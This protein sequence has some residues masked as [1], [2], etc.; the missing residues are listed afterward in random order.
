MEMMKPKR[1]NRWLFKR[2]I[3]NT[4]L[5]SIDL[6][7]KNSNGD[8]LLNFRGNHPAYHKWFF[9]GGS[10][11]KPEKPRDAFLSIIKR[12]FFSVLKLDFNDAKFTKLAVHQYKEDLTG[13]VKTNEEGIQYYVLCYEFTKDISDSELQNILVLYEENAKR[14]TLIN[15]I[16]TLI[17]FKVEPDVIGIK[18]FSEEQLMKD[19]DVHDNVKLYFKNDPD[20]IIGTGF[21]PPSKI[22]QSSSNS[23]PYRLQSLL[24]LYQTQSKSI[25]SYTT[26]I[27]AFPIVF[28]VALGNIYRYFHQSE[29][30]MILSIWFSVVMHQAFRKHTY[31][32][33]VLKNSLDAIERSI[34]EE[35]EIM[36][37]VMP[38]WEP[39]N[40]YPK[41]H[42]AV[43][44]FL[45]IFTVLFVILI[46]F[47]IMLD[48][49]IGQQF[50][51]L[52]WIRDHILLPLNFSNHKC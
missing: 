6:I 27:W 34:K 39:V 51:F 3:K 23:D 15:K 24:T 7:I 14:K 35:S 41:S 16:K 33:E 8:Y 21:I 49:N 2:I 19:V 22:E 38:N 45:K 4:P 36:N 31:I 26:V 11:K 42:I 44:S 17:G 13:Y 18:W 9:F 40:S 30:I 10:I 48:V 32:H 1:P 47:T 52:I 12:E 50:H 43:R 25:N 28:I 5:V 37:K 46:L 20:I 29:L